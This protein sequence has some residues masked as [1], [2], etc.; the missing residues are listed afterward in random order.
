MQGYFCAMPAFL[1]TLVI[2]MFFVIGAP[3]IGAAQS[4]QD[5]ARKAYKAGEI[6]PLN[7][8]LHVVKSRHPGRVMDVD[9]QR[10][11]H[12]VYRIKILTREGDV[13]IVE[14][15]ASTANI[16]SVR[17]GGRARGRRR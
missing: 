2:A 1:L 3:H 10:G 13:L 12:W 9:L 7:K 14:V 8:V 11:G 5:R 6:Q 15:D 17:G 4:A 16:M